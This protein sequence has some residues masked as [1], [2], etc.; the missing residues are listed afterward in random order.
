ML[1]D[2]YFCLIKKK[3]INKETKIN[4]KKE[5]NLVTFTIDR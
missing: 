2:L 5:K 1:K 3:E 4:M